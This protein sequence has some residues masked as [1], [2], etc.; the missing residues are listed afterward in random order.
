M[1]FRSI[2]MAIKGTLMDYIRFCPQLQQPNW[3]ESTRSVK[4]V[5]DYMAHPSGLRILLVIFYCKLSRY[6]KLL[7]DMRCTVYSQDKQTAVFSALFS[8]RKKASMRISFDVETSWRL[9]QLQRFLH[10]QKSTIAKHEA[11]VESS[12][13]RHFMAE[14]R[15]C[16]DT[17][18]R[19][20]EEKNV[21]DFL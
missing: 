1:R 15:H 21:L 19:R 4:N 12:D 20:D 14:Q 18:T 10:G 17:A 5:V 11:L 7:S 8:R 3:R 6:L 13:K 16:K 9:L 2:K